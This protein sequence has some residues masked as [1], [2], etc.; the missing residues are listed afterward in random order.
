VSNIKAVNVNSKAIVSQR[1]IYD[2]CPLAL[3]PDTQAILHCVSMPSHVAR[4]RERF[5]KYL[6]ARH[7]EQNLIYTFHVGRFSNCISQEHYSV[8]DSANNPAFRA[9]ARGTQ[10]AKATLQHLSCGFL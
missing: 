2:S 7:H 5:A 10:Q 4:F 6:R 8:P 9:N 3:L 1:Y